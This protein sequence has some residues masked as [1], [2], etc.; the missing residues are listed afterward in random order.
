MKKNMGR[1]G[2]LKAGAKMLPTL[3]AMGIV[4]TAVATPAMA[5]QG[6]D[7]GCFTT[8]KDTCDSTCKGN[9]QGDCTG[10]CKGEQR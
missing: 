9:C 10:S 2:F 6:C 5:C 7:N 3:A 1:R 4:M 8:C